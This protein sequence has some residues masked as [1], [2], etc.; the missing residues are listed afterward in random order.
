MVTSIQPLILN[1]LK[2]CLNVAFTERLNK[3]RKQYFSFILALIMPATEKKRY[4]I[5]LMVISPKKLC[6]LPTTPS[7]ILLIGK[8]MWHYMENPVSLMKWQQTLLK[9]LHMA[10]EKKKKK[11]KK[12]RKQEAAAHRN[13]KALP[14]LDP[15]RSCH[16]LL[17]LSLVS[18]ELL[19]L[20]YNQKWLRKPNTNPNLIPSP[21]EIII[22]IMISRFEPYIKHGGVN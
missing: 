10:S 7:W 17:L 15:T 19:T 13:F 8:V 3:H 6:A 20:K 4:S 21:I 18:P 14:A 5:L 1:I 22:H 11:K 9:A 2:K 16:P 12:N